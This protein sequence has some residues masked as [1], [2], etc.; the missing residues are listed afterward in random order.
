MLG[1]CRPQAWLGGLPSSRAPCWQRSPGP[2]GVARGRLVARPLRR[3]YSEAAFPT[4]NGVGIVELLTPSQTLLTHCA[5]QS[6]ENRSGAA[7]RS[8]VGAC[9]GR[10]GEPAGLCF[11]AGEQPDASL[12]LHVL[13]LYSL[14]APEKQAQVTT[15][16]GLGWMLAG[17][18]AGAPPKGPGRRAGQALGCP[19]HQWFDQH[20][21]F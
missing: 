7:G 13:P 16:W 3:S 2:R 11:P 21:Q 19:R 14:L 15:A 1:K 17:C 20:P 8:E 18:L 6:V 9:R 5:V 10:L 12:P 4:G